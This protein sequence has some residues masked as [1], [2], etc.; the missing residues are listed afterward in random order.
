MSLGFVSFS[1]GKSRIGGSFARFGERLEVHFG[2]EG[3]DRL[4][5]KDAER[6][7]GDLKALY[8]AASEKCQGEWSPPMLGECFRADCP[9]A[10]WSSPTKE[11]GSR[12][13]DTSS[14]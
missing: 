14:G 8:E 10:A 2:M 12:M 1:A 5:R 7:V 3:P 11:N 6:V 9:R 13:K 4:D